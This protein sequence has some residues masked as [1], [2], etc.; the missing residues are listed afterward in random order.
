M[1]IN[2]NLHGFF[3]QCNKIGGQGQSFSIV[4]IIEE[5]KWLYPAVMLGWFYL[6]A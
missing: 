4:H 3:R 2:E 6:F 5:D 1:C